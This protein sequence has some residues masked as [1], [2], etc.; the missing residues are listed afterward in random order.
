MAEPV[1]EVIPPLSQTTPPAEAPPPK[2]APAGLKPNRAAQIREAIRATEA[3][4]PGEPA[5]DDEKPAAPAAAA[6][7][8]PEEK[9]A[10]TPAQPSP[11]DATPQ[12]GKAK[13]WADVMAEQHRVREAARAL[14]ERE[15]KVKEAEEA[16]RLLRE[17]PVA[18]AA[19]FGGADFGKK[20]VTK[21]I[22]DGKATPEEALEEARAARA[23]LA[24]YKKREEEAKQ[25]AEQRRQ[26]DEYVGGH[27][28][29]MKDDKEAALLRGW[30]EEGELPRVIESIA[31][32]HYAETQ[33][34]L[35]P[36]QLS[37][38]V[39]RELKTRL[40]RI[41]KTEAGR[42]YLRELLKDDPTSSAG[43]P[44]PRAPATAPKTLSQDLNAASAAPDLGRLRSPK[45]KRAI[46]QEAIAAHSRE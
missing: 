39:T 12:A 35:T 34:V 13:A 7:P 38:T 18:Y 43:Q 1:V 3:A 40:E 10:E 6:A 21:T 15:A 37:G 16:A 41:S 2:A 20:F 17:D 44:K 14:K 29:H 23:E 33:E 24:E 27:V 36:P 42:Q 22:N 19:K 8:K 46:I 25:Q 31:Q 11:E 26:L 5:D 45:D 4:S 28:R 9:P 30:Y 32:R